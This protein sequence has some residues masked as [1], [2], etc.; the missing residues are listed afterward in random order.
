MSNGG[1]RYV[2][3]TPRM[4]TMAISNLMVWSCRCCGVMAEKFSWLHV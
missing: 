3:K 2:G 4:F 1:R